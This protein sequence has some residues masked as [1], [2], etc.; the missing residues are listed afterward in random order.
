MAIVIPA[1]QSELQIVVSQ[2]KHLK[3]V[4]FGTPRFAVP[5]LRRLVAD[6]WPVALVVT[7]PDKPFGRKQEL[8]PSPVKKAAQEL[9]IAVRTPQTLKDESFWN[10]FSE[11][12]PD[13]CVVVAYNKIIPQRYLDLARLGF[14]NVHPSML[15]LYRGPSPIQSAILDGCDTTGVSIMLLDA[16]VDHGP[17]LAQEPW[18]IPSGFDY[19]ACEGELARIGADLL[20]RTL[21]EYVRGSIT[22]QVQNHAE[23]TFTKKFTRD[24]GRIDWTRPARTIINQIRALGENPGTWTM[25]HETPLNIFEAHHGNSPVLPPGT[26]TEE[27]GNLGVSCADGI[28]ILDTIQIAGGKRMSGRDF[29]RGHRELIHT[30]YI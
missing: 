20:T 28:I 4:F 16:E 29:L 23:A 19:A 17:V 30:Q 13:L 22:P 21:A 7:A 6:G 9:G 11:L 12:R 2:E 25:Q 26:I 1:P 10:E 18:Q 24:D 27:A 14:I 8:T 15:P 3:I 5:S